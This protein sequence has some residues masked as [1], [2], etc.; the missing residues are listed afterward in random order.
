VNDITCGVQHL[1]NFN[2]VHG[3]IK[4][5]N[6]LVDLSG[7]AR[8]ADFGLTNVFDDNILKWSSAGSGSSVSGGT[9]RWRAPELIR[10]EM[11]T[12]RTPPNTLS[13]DVYSWACTA[14]EVL[15]GRVP[16]FEIRSSRHLDWR[17]TQTC[18]FFPTRPSPAEAKFTNGLW[19]LLEDCWRSEPA[20]RPKI[21]AV[22]Q[23]LEGLMD[24]SIP[25]RDC[26]TS[27]YLN[28]SCR[29]PDRSCSWAQSSCGGGEGFLPSD[30]DLRKVVLMVSISFTRHTGEV[31]KQDSSDSYLS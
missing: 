23:R 20:Q 25:A 11:T 14:Y 30:E 7:R 5:A 31:A 3:D 18:D 29:G 13:S 15:T 28:G 2:V 12:D 9:S 22:L 21:C 17:K 26:T 1:H 24:S 16:F 6:V 19:R 4:G 8:L 10:Q 27:S